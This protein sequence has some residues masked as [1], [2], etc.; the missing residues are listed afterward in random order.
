M[1]SV[2]SISSVVASLLADTSA[3]MAPTASAA[4]EQFNQGHVDTARLDRRSTRIGP[5]GLVSNADANIAWRLN[6]VASCF[7]AGE[8]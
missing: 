1:E 7:G 4:H 3:S 6:V 8:L 2:P 5:D